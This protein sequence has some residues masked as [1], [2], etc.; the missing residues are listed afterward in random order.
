[1]GNYRTEWP[2]S[3]RLSGRCRYNEFNQPYNDAAMER[4]EPQWIT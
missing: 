1:M 3:A 4:M 2:G